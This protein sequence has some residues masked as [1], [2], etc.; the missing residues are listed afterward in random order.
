M[1][2]DCK[3]QVSSERCAGFFFHYIQ[4]MVR[5]CYHTS[6][7]GN[8]VFIAFLL[9]AF[10]QPLSRDFFLHMKTKST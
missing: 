2:N 3:L 7:K 4:V 6:Q 5:V 10:P 8:G 1:R 9:Q